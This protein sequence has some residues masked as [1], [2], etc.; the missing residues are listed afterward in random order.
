[1]WTTMLRVSTVG[2]GHMNPDPDLNG[3]NR[4]L[5]QWASGVASESG[6]QITVLDIGANEGEFTAKILSLLPNVR[7]HCFEPNPPT[8]ARLK[9]RFA[10]DKRVI[11]NNVG[12]GSER[13]S[14][15]LCDYEE[16]EGSGHA[17]L[18]SATF[19]DLY[20]KPATTT[21]VNIITLDEYAVTNNLPDIDY[22]KIDVEGF[23]MEVFMGMRKTIAANTPKHI[24]FEFNSHNAITGLSLYRISKLLPGYTIRKILPNGTIAILGKGLPYNSRAELF[25]YSNFVA[26]FDRQDLPSAKT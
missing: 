19:E 25:R 3:E 22:C 11:L 12:L 15:T 20:R 10:H 23:E 26:T 16:G 5:E 14:L 9:T 2:L 18:L 6:V 17:S 24:Q 21:S 1:M 4:Q 13:G 7:V 8:F